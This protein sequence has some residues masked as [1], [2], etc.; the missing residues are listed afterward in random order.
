MYTIN[1][2][3]NVKSPQ[4]I[5]NMNID[6]FFTIIKNGDE[7]ISNIKK[8]REFGKGSDGYS[9]IKSTLLPTFR[10]N[11]QF[12]HS[13]N[14]ANIMAST[15]LIYIDIDNVDFIPWSAHTFAAWQSLSTK[16][17]SILVKVENLNIHNFSETY[18]NIA[19]LLGI[20]ADRNAGKITQQ[21]VL[22]F[23][24]NIYINKN[25][26]IYKANDSKV[27]S[28]VNKKK[29]E[30]LCRN[31]TSENLRFNNIDEYFQDDNTYLFF[32]NEKVKICEPFVPRKVEVGG[33][34]TAVFTVISQ[35]AVLNPSLNM[36]ELIRLAK[37]YNER[38][39][40]KLEYR[41]LSAVVR[42]VV[43][44][45][46]DGNLYIN[47]NKERRFLFNPKFK[48]SHSQKML[49]VNQKMGAVKREATEQKIYDVIESWGFEKLGLINQK[50]VSDEANLSIATIKRYWKL[51]KE[52]VGELNSLFQE[53]ENLDN[54]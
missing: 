29:E 8:A 21:T 34:N 17:Y 13:A 14:N 25:S 48:I 15:G 54:L 31:D 43:K 42:S 11:F 9:K 30:S 27:S 5:D 38:F 52:F 18:N 20:D 10:F 1:K 28:L 50:K 39:C 49:I 4:V 40:P 32:E 24:E 19:T 35:L 2:F 37:S 51:F 45:R 47:L 7:N 12:K 46:K 41:E 26:L 36:D 3:K 53:Q 22:S 6:S 33:R 23:D 44:M 16:G